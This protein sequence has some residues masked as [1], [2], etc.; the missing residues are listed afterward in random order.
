MATLTVGLGKQFATHILACKAMLPGD[1]VLSDPGVYP[2]DRI[3]VTPVQKGVTFQ[4]AVP[5]QRARLT[6]EPGTPQYGNLVFPGY[7][8]TYAQ[9]GI[10]VVNGDDVT[11]DGFEFIGA[12]SKYVTNAAGIRHNGGKNLTVK[13]GACSGGDNGILGSEVE[14]HATPEYDGGNVTLDNM[15][16]EQNGHRGGGQAHNCY[17]GRVDT[18][19]ATRIVSRRSEVGHLFKGRAHKTIIEDSVFDDG[20]GWSSMQVDCDGGELVLL[21]NHFVK[22]P[23]KRAGAPLVSVNLYNFIYYYVQ[24]ADSANYAFIARENFFECQLPIQGTFIKADDRIIPVN[25]TWD[26]TSRVPLHV[27]VS[28]NQYIA[29]TGPLTYET[30]KWQLPAGATVMRNVRKFYY[31]AASLLTAASTGQIPPS[32]PP[33]SPSA[34]PTSEAPKTE[35]VKPTEPVRTEPVRK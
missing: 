14:D 21:R 4:C 27:E 34:T 2:D 20:D 7:N 25:T 26:G 33:T 23:V 19:K 6:C 28:Y 35:P 1:L 30:N 9:K 12:F 11:F 29:G 17:F 15:M 24:H 5:N 3:A 10:G 16:F 32:A 8:A 31:S 13:N 22:R 18:L